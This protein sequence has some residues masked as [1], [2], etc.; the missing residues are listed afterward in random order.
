[1][2][3]RSRSA[4]SLSRTQA[5]LN[6]DCPS[7]HTPACPKKQA[8]THTQMHYSTHA[9]RPSVCSM[10]SE[11]TLRVI[12]TESARAALQRVR[13]RGGRGGGGGDGR[14]H[15]DESP[16]P[17][18]LTLFRIFQS[19]A[20]KLK[21]ESV[22]ALCASSN[23]CQPDIARHE[24]HRE[25]IGTYRQ[26]RNQQVAAFSRCTQVAARTESIPPHLYSK[27]P[28]VVDFPEST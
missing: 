12:E 21:R 13:G 24:S 28:V 15:A 3:P 26:S 7:Q 14:K 8:G 19:Y 10:R 6:E 1:M 11:S 27:C 5:Y 4:L 9:R 2:I 25:I 23:E 20:A 22:R 17:F 16:C 18:L